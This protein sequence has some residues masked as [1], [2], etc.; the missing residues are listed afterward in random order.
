MSSTTAEAMEAIENLATKGLFGINKALNA[1][2]KDNTIYMMKA[3]KV[4]GRPLNNTIGTGVPF[5]Y[6][7][8]TKSRV[9]TAVKHT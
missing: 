7:N 1:P 6:S 4:D 9:V 2:E 8:G 5:M 3:W